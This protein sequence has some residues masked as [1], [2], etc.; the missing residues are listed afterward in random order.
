MDCR[1]NNRKVTVLVI[2][3]ANFIKIKKSKCCDCMMIKNGCSTKYINI[4]WKK[5]CIFLPSKYNLVE[6]KKLR[7]IL[8][9]DV[10]D[11][12]QIYYLLRPH[13]SK[14]YYSSSLWPV[15]FIFESHSSKKKWL[16]DLL[17]VK[18]NDVIINHLINICDYNLIS[19]SL[20]IL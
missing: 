17:L 1:H 2:M 9:V 3:L 11:Y 14:I 8:V 12:S 18:K 16:E 20:V 7:Q 4:N 15:L 19:C 6:E 13:M 10:L 5:W